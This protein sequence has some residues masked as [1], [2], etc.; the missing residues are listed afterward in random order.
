VG[1]NIR[2]AYAAFFTMWN[3][4]GTGDGRVDVGGGEHHAYDCWSRSC[5]R[6]HFGTAIFS[7]VEILPGAENA[8]AKNYERDGL[9]A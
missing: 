6:H 4:I 7:I 1:E 3:F 9:A 8:Y 2:T 5:G